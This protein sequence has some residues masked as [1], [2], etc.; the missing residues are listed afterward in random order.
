[1][2]VEQAIEIEN[3]LETVVRYFEHE[4]KKQTEVLDIKLKS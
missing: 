1:M 3:K 4:L 2:I